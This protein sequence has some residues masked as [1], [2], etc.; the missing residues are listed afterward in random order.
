[1]CTL[2]LCGR[3]RNAIAFEQHLIRG[4]G[5]A[6]DAN[7]VV[8]WVP[9]ANLLLDDLLDRRPFGDLD[10]I[11][12]TAAVIIDEQNFHKTFFVVRVRSLR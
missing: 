7:Q 11:S 5:Q 8:R 1:M 3:D 2:D 12:K 9:G 10:K 4:T 6:I